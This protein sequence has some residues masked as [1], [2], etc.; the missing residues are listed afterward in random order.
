LADAH[1]GQ[2]NTTADPL[3]SYQ[4]DDTLPFQIS[5][6]LKVLN[7]YDRYKKRME[8][9]REDLADAKDQIAR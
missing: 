7:G 3:S 2:E 4:L 6:V 8:D 5:H 1:V 9:I